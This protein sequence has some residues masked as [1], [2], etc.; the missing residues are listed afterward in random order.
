MKAAGRRSETLGVSAILLRVGSA[1]EFWV[2]SVFSSALAPR[3]R[4]FRSATGTD[5]A[6]AIAAACG[7]WSLG[8]QI[9]RGCASRS[10]PDGRLRRRP[11]LEFF[12]V[13]AVLA[14]S[15]PEGVV[16]AVAPPH[17]DKVAMVT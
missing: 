3:H 13:I 1:P 6:D 5:A 16:G 14:R 11:Q 4:R 7:P 12:A 8:A 17:K 9:G 15:P 2:S 10:T